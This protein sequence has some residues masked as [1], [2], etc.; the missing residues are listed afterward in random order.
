MNFEMRKETIE[1]LIRQV[2]GEDYMARVM[3]FKTK[4]GNV[5]QHTGMTMEKYPLEYATTFLMLGPMISEL[6]ARQIANVVHRAL[7][8]THLLRAV[9]QDR[10]ANER[11]IAAHEF[12]LKIQFQMLKALGS[13]AGVDIPDIPALDQD[14]VH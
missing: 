11:T 10:E 7:A 8:I 9:D 13:E 6:S 2:H 5:V 3:R 1:E 4:L 12:S 14:T